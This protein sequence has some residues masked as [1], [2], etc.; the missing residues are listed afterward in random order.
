MQKTNKKCN[1]SQGVFWFIYPKGVTYSSPGL[2]YPPTLGKEEKELYP[3]GVASD[4]GC[5]VED[6]KSNSRHNPVG[7]ERQKSPDPG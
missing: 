3:E 7:V 5:D 6:R 4:V 1:Y 2:A